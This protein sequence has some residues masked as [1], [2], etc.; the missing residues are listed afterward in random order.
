MDVLG[1]FAPRVEIYS[2]DEAFLDWSGFAEDGLIEYAQGM[3]GTVRRW[4]GLPVSV[5]IGPTQVL[6]KVANRIAKKQHVPGGVVALLERG[7]QA[8]ALAGLEMADLWGIA[9]RWS[10]QLEALG[11]E[12]ALQLR[13]ADPP[14]LRSA[15]G[16]VMERIVY[17]LRGISCL[18]LEEVAPAKR[19]IVASRSFGRPVVD[20]GELKEAVAFHVARA[21]VRLRR[22]GSE[23]GGLQVFVGTNPFAPDDPHYRGACTV[24]LPAPTADTGALIG[25]AMR[26]LT[27]IYR[28]GYRYK[29]AGIMLLSLSSAGRRQGELFDL[30]DGER[31]RALMA[32]LDAVNARMG[33]GTLRFGTEG[34]RQP[35]AM[36]QAPLAG[37][38]DAVGR[39]CH[40]WGESGAEGLA[41]VS[42]QAASAHLWRVPKKAG[43]DKKISRHPLRHTDAINPPKAGGE[44][45]DIKA[46]PG[47]E[48]VAIAL[49]SHQTASEI[50]EAVQCLTEKLTLGPTDRALLAS[51]RA[52]ASRKRAAF[53][54]GLPSRPRSWSS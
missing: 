21:A 14:L 20:L 46:L 9:A 50:P 16:V 33:L 41:P 11:I 43:I 25:Q 49:D 52:V 1:R 17:E 13:D 32:T 47:H 18:A 8:E 30:G 35:W 44:L 4:L 24:E 7:G 19:Q 42:A 26:G 3:V 27:A 15:F 31:S 51:S 5:G 54:P 48:S 37:L 45:V 53:E 12:T 29:K 34:F 40:R 22:Q 38:H 2:I 28:E 6:A 23:A 10:A 36:R 39:R